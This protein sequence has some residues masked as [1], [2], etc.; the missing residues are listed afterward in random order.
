VSGRKEEE[1]ARQRIRTILR[2]ASLYAWGFFAAAFATA[3]GGAAIAAWVLTSAGLPFLES[4][5][6]MSA[7]VLVPSL[8]GIVWRALREPVAGPDDDRSDPVG[9]VNEG[10]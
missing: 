6:V 1:A 2:K 7:I 5:L 3:L 9:E 10:N 8:I 4:W